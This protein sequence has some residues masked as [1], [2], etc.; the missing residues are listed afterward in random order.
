MDSVQNIQDNKIIAQQMS[1]NNFNICKDHVAAFLGMTSSIIDRNNIGPLL[2]I[3]KE[4]KEYYYRNLY[5]NKS[6]DIFDSLINTGSTS[7]LLKLVSAI[8]KEKFLDKKTINKILMRNA[9]PKLAGPLTLFQECVG[10]VDFG[11]GKAQAVI[12]LLSDEELFSDQD[13]Q[14]IFNEKTYYD[15]EYMLISEFLRRDTK[16]IDV[17]HFMEL[18]KKRLSKDTFNKIIQSSEFNKRVQS[19]LK[20]KILEILNRK[21]Y[22]MDKVVE[23]KGHTKLLRKS[24]FGRYF[25]IQK[26]LENELEI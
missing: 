20:T 23:T 22:A 16:S 8:I 10:N 15:K 14:Y 3:T 6:R 25:D 26:E 5:N 11:Q 24:K 21:E 13:L 17:F 9:N 19:E 18:M 12:D 7:S 1:E 2:L 4:E